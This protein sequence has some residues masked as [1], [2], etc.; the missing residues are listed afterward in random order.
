MKPRTNKRT[1]WQAALKYRVIELLG[2]DVKLYTETIELLGYDFAWHYTNH[3][4][5]SVRYLTRATSYWEWWKKQWQLREECFLEEFKG[6]A[7]TGSE[8]EL[9]EFWLD[10]HQ[11]V[12]VESYPG[13]WVF[14]ESY[15]L[16]LEEVNNEK[17]GLLL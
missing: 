11:P 10:E 16:M 7:G 17:G 9:R 8:N 3:D 5:F 4:E 2:M 15:R 12:K 13:P 14:E 6:Y 1:G